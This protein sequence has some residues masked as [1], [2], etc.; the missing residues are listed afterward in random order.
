MLFAS[1]I[2]APDTR[3]AAVVPQVFGATQEGGAIPVYGQM[4]ATALIRAVPVAVLYLLFQRC[5]V[6]GLTTGGLKR[7]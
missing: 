5:L 2:T 3:T 7:P 6:N 1:V 4:M